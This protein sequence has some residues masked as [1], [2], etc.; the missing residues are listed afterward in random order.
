M[1]ARSTVRTWR[2]FG[3]QAR[4]RIELELA[5]RGEAH[6]PGCSG[7]LA[8]RPSTRLAAVLPS[9]ARGLDLECRPCR[10]F[11]ARVQHTPSSLY[12]LRLQRLAAAV[13]RA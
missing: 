10:R 9:G 2:R 12:V 8:E 3:R 6:C 4:E 7:A 5:I 11:H 13:L 1:P